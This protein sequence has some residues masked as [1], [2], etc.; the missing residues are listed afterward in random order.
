MSLYLTSQQFLK[1]SQLMYEVCGICLK[2]GK[3]DFVKLRLLKRLRALGIKTFEEYFEFLENDPAQSELH[4]LIDVMTTNK[5]EFFREKGHFNYLRQ[6][7][8]PEL[9][10]PKLRF[11]SAGCSSGEEPFSLAIILWEEISEIVKLDV[12][13]LATDI[14]LRMLDKVRQACYPKDSVR[15]IPPLWVQKYFF[16]IPNG[17]H[18]I[19]RL[20]DEVRKLVHVAR[21]NLLDPWPMKGPFHVIFCRN[22]M[23]Y[24]D[25]QT[26]QKLIR[27]FWEYL[28]PG[29]YL[30]LGHSERI[31][32]FKHNFKYKKPAIYQK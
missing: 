25:R 30:F 11:W 23:I 13:I 6:E 4:L 5:T 24:F 28:E 32:S 31:A 1:I 7:V 12:K 16:R 3:E 8:L 29:G 10:G 2:P 20:K 21:L 14:S 18:S 17:P 9:I 19:Y 27:R 15:G 26:Q 22:V